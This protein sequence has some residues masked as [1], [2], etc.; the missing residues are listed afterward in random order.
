M[1][2]RYWLLKYLENKTGQKEE[3]VVLYK[4]QNNY[5]ILIKEYM[6]ECSLPLSS[7]IGLKP[8]DLIQITIQHVNARKDLLCVFMG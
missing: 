8:Q 1:R 7:G 5:Q 2:N 6:I 4:R 3:A